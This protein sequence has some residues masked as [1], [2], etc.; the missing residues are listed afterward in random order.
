MLSKWN[1]RVTGS[2]GSSICFFIAW[3]SK[4]SM[5]RIYL[6]FGSDRLAQVL[7][8]KNL[9]QGKGLMLGPTFV[10]NLAQQ[11]YLPAIKN[12]PI[13]WPP[14]YSL[15]LAPFLSITKDFTVAVFL[16]DILIAFLYLFFLRKSLRLLKFPRPIINLFLIYQGLLVPYYGTTDLLALTFLLIALYYLAE[17]VSI[18]AFSWKKITFMSVAMVTTAMLRYQY[19]PICFL[20]LLASV[21]YGYFHRAPTVYKSGLGVCAILLLVCGGWFLYQKSQGLE[22]VYLAPSAKGYFPAN[23]TLTHP[24]AFLGFINTHFYFV[25]LA[26]LL[27]AR[28]AIVYELFQ[29]INLPIVAICIFGCIKFIVKRVRKPVTANSSFSLLLAFT[30]LIIILELI[31]LS[32]FLSSDVGPPLFTWTYV[33]GARYFMLPILA[34]QICAWNWLFRKK[35]TLSP[36]ARALRILLAIVVIIEIAHGAYLISKNSSVL[37]QPV[38][39]ALV[40]ERE[41]AFLLNYLRH[42][43]DSSSLVVSSFLRRFAFLA[44]LEGHSALYDPRALNQDLNARMPIRIVLIVRDVERP[45]LLPF[46]NKSKVA[47][48]GREAE[49]SFYKYEVPLVTSE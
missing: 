4:V 27:N 39:T 31:F 48:I 43:S 3:V 29:W 32:L 46:L 11:Y 33:M 24:F 20:V 41:Y 47:L 15:L 13:G 25:Q 45:Y 38:K 19:Q 34:I 49:F 10:Q 44:Q 26:Q 36:F 21:A 23:I 17:I 40:K 18:Q 28:Y 14:A 7:I 35:S 9:L 8:A 16:L 37:S 2:V 5:I 6:D 30:S 1:P 22:G 12:P 42:R